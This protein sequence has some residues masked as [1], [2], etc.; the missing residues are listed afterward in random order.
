MVSSRVMCK[1][2]V[3]KVSGDTVECLV[4]FAFG[5]EPWTVG[6]WLK[7]KKSTRWGRWGGEEPVGVVGGG[8]RVGVRLTGGMLRGKGLG[9]G[10]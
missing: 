2:E 8:L 9:V 6:C 10:N 7:G 5:Y 4:A 1:L 3:G